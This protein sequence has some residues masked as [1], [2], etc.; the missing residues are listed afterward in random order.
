MSAL[1]FVG[2]RVAQMSYTRND[3]YQLTD[4]PLLLHPVPTTD[5]DVTDD[6]IKV[7]LTIDVG[8]LTG[9]KMPFKVTC[10][11]IGDFVYE[12]AEDKGAVALDTLVRN[13]AVAILYPYVRAV[14][15]TLT[16]TSGEFPSYN[17]PTINVSEWLADTRKD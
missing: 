10:A 13:N 11:L 9:K 1:K 7:T 16:N 5:I 17:L 3:H 15:A 12:S 4:R 2:Y 6:R 14:I 8:S